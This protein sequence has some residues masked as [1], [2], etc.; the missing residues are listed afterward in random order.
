MASKQ[1]N[2]NDI[3]LKSEQ[4]EQ[5]EQSD[6]KHGESE[7][8]ESESSESESSESESE[9]EHESGNN[10]DKESDNVPFTED[11]NAINGSET[12]DVSKDVPDV[13]N[14]EQSIVDDFD[15][16]D[17]FEIPSEILNGSTKFETKDISK[18]RPDVSNS[19][20]SSTESKDVSKDR[21]DVSNS[22]QS[23]T[24]SKPF[25][26]RKSFPVCFWYMARPNE[27]ELENLIE[28]TTD[29]IKKLIDI[30]KVDIYLISGDREKDRIR[31]ICPEIFVNIRVMKDI[32]S[33]ILEDLGYKVV[34]NIIPVLIY[35]VLSVPTILT[36][37]IWDMG[38]DKWET[39]QSYFCLNKKDVK[40]EKLEK[41]MLKWDNESKELSPFTAKYIE[42]MDI[43]EDGDNSVLEENELV[44]VVM[45]DR[46][47]SDEIKKEVGD[48]LDKTIEWFK[49]Y[50]SDS[51][52]RVIK[53]HKNSPDVFIL[54]FTKSKKK[55]RLCNLIHI[56]NRQYVT[57]SNK[58]K[59]AYYHCH[60]SDAEGKRHVISFAKPKRGSGVVSVA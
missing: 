34:A 5:S 12:K 46:V 35:E 60:D 25:L 19:E 26:L 29:T 9:L 32:R 15:D 50:H 11:D 39:Y 56:S 53:R 33:L 4:S 54:D 22:E 30:E 28:I 21:P 44:S 43:R 17:D 38:L 1:N 3:E 48:N 55:C 52:L 7:S 41:L 18:D 14:A 16:F 6:F 40:P 42:Y 37:R 20:Q 57:Y 45:G 8:S 31:V 47:I 51:G 27:K 23:S 49:K 2:V 10:S 13:S 59:K 36:P 24:E 58:S